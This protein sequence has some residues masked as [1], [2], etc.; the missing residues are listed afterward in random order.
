[1]KLNLGNNIRTN[2]RRMN[3][4][5]EQLAEKLGV[6]YQ[7]I[8]RWE[9]GTT[10]PDLELLPSLAGIFETTVDALLGCTEDEK[11]QYCDELYGKL[12]EAAK[13]KDVD[14]VVTALREIR[15]N[16]RE[17]QDYW[18]W[19]LYNEIWKTRLHL[20]DKV[21]DEL[22]LLTEEI[23]LV[24]P[25]YLHSVSVEWMAT[26]E[27]DDHIDAFLD[28]NASEEE[29]TRTKLLFE[30]YK[31]RGELDKI[32]PVR[33]FY[34]WCKLTD[35]DAANDWQEYLCQDGAHWKWFCETQLGYLNAVNALSPTPEHIVSGSDTIDLWC[36]ERIHLGL[37][38]SC[39]LAKLGDNDRSFMIFEDTVSLLERVMAIPDE[40]T[41]RLGCNSPALRGFTLESK[42]YWMDRNDGREHRQLEMKCNEFC[43]WIIPISYLES[44]G[45]EC[46]DQMRSDPRWEGYIKRLQACVITREK[47]N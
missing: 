31:M 15:R 23:F 36:M 14:G 37:R 12:E 22:R 32:E 26:M 4:T 28:I 34:L 41:F 13:N 40:D 47:Q 6:S 18:F 20:N 17:Y 25:H 24:C 35:I 16:L 7:A 3:L 43:N 30:R 27:D 39:A 19:G 8:S 11:K 46:Y 44:F 42:F 2:R 10:Y 1:M 33:K 9:N 5:Q 21:L 45:H 29:L 38:Y